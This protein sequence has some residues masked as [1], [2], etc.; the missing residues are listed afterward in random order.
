MTYDAE[1]K[2][3]TVTY[4]KYADPGE[5]LSNN[6]SQAI[7][8]HHKLFKRLE[9]RDAVAAFDAKIQDGV[10]RGVWRKATAADLDYKGPVNYIVLTEAFKESEGATTPVR[11]CLDASRKKNGASLN[12]ILVPGP[13]RLANQ[14]EILL[15][16]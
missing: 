11:V 16:F 4:P 8:A 9:Q 2:K 10:S 3:W 15:D 5:V 1:N 6:L 14:L 12:S 7:N 13:S